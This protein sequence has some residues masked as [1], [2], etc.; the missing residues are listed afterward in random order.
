MT[1]QLLEL[2]ID[3]GL[4]AAALAL[5]IGQFGVPLPT[6]L[7]LLT[8][9]ALA[10]NGDAELLT[11]FLWAV[12]GT[13]L[14]DQAGYLT[15]RFVAQSAEDRPGML[16][17]L[18]RKARAAEPRIAKWGASG[19]FFTRWLFTP[20]GPAV[21]IASG[22]ARFSWV[23][24]TTWGVAGEVLWVSIYMALGYTFG[25]NIE[26]LA[27]IFGNLS[28]A[29]AMLALA[30]FLGWRLQLAIRKAQGRSNAKDDDNGH[31]EV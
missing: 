23:I 19:V 17:G 29:L 15:G 16:G 5:A 20:L 28:M 11:A 22:V 3:Y 27:G 13:T 10:A 9:G 26:T 12:T 4:P 8:L 25:S 21:N 7:A 6:S 1:D 31:A 2:L 24:F 30:A 18:A 14:G